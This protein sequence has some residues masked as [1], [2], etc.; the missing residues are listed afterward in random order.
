L[1]VPLYHTDSN[2]ESCFVLPLEPVNWLP[3]QGLHLR[4]PLGT[5][6]SLPVSARRVALVA[7]GESVLILQGLIKPAL[8]QGAAVV[9]VTDSAL[10]DDLPSA[11]EVQPFSALNDVLGWADYAAFDVAR[12]A[13][14][15]LRERLGDGQQA[16]AGYEAQVF[17]RMPVPCGG[18]AECGVCAVNVRSGWRLGCKDGPVFALRD[19]F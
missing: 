4:G 19:L 8:K 6:F 1:P 5:G 17:V 15:Q 9:I 11:V 2:A 16:A 14:F 12:E 18:V 7:F 13:L 10:D 3:G